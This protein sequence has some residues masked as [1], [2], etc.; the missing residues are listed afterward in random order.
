[1]IRWKT[2]MV[3]EWETPDT[4][5][6]LVLRHAGEL[7]IAA[8]YCSVD[9]DTKMGEALTDAER[10]ARQNGRALLIDLR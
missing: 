1:M 3:L 7:A 10:R 6:N 2:P 4:D 9:L 8:R 5:Q